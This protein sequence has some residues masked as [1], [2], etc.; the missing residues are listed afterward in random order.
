MELFNK[1]D[2]VG[3]VLIPGN[4]NH[5]FDENYEPTLETLHVFKILDYAKN[6]KDKENIDFPVLG[7]C[8]G[9]EA[10]AL[11]ECYNNK[12]NFKEC[13]VENPQF[14]GTFDLIFDESTDHKIRYP[15]FFKKFSHK[16]RKKSFKNVYFH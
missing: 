8:F 16:L 9:M 13:M 4:D 6:K 12:V 10:I 11:W 3:G 1:L 5:P 7:I 15:N 14:N 2:S